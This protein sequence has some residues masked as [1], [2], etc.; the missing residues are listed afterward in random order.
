M[1]AV[2]FA[3]IIHELSLQITV[4]FPSISVFTESNVSGVPAHETIVE[5]TVP[6]NTSP[7]GR[8]SSI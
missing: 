7:S 2:E 8:R 5:L 1:R 3:H 6:E 4:V